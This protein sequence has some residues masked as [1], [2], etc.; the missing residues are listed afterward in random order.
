LY[1]RAHSGQRSRGQLEKCFKKYHGS[2]VLFTTFVGGVLVYVYRAP[3]LS[4]VSEQIVFF[5][6]TPT[7]EL[8]EMFTN[9]L[10]EPNIAPFTSLY[11]VIAVIILGIRTP[12]R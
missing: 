4:W 11:M 6:N 8:W 1:C 2:I 12:L 3:I 10:A 5:Q 9:Y 7:G